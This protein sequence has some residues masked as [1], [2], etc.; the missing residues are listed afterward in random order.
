MGLTLFNVF[1]GAMDSGDPAEGIE[2]TLSKFDNNTKLCGALNMLERRDA[3]QRDMDRLKKSV[4]GN[5]T[6]FNKAKAK[7]LHMV[8]AILIIHQSSL[9]R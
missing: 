3:I 1:A 5:L 2:R 4:H 8:G 6:G 7:V 9:S